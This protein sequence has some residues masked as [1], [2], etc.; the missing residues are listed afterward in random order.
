M[1]LTPRNNLI[2]SCCPSQQTILAREY[3][4]TTMTPTRNDIDP[5]DPVESCGAK[6]STS[7][8]P[9]SATMSSVQE[10][11]T[12]EPVSLP[13]SNESSSGMVSFN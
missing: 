10:A 11:A 3:Q 9:V 12:N 4:A 6:Y 2:S 13:T 8:E 7:L 1:S 5:S